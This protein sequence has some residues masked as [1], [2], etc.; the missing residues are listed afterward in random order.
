MAPWAIDVMTD[1]PSFKDNDDFL[2][3][4]WAAQWEETRLLAWWNRLS[5]MNRYAVLLRVD[6]IFRALNGEECRHVGE[7]A[8]EVDEILAEMVPRLLRLEKFAWGIR[9]A[10]DLSEIEASIRE[11]DVRDEGEDAI[12]AASYIRWWNSLS[13]KE[14]DLAMDRAESMLGRSVSI[15]DACVIND[16]EVAY[17]L[18]QLCAEAQRRAAGDKAQ[19]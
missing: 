19:D 4:H 10:R 14:R 12:F 11:L 15:A 7:L 1:D 13:L 2:A 16:H 17:A 18:E 8:D 6:K 9:R 3:A 5:P